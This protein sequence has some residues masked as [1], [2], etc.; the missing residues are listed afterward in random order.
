MEM[1]AYYYYMNYLPLIINYDSKLI[2]E[3]KT[4]LKK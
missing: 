4:Q 3:T 2:K 1:L